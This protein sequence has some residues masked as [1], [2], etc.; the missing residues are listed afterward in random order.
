MTAS[1][2][3]PRLPRTG[4]P[5]NGPREEMKGDRELCMAAVTQDGKALQWASE[6]MKGDRE[7]CTAAVA[8]NRRALEFASEEMKGDRELCTAAVAQDG[9]ALQYCSE[10]MKG[11]RELCTAAVAQNW[12]ALEWAGE[13]MKGDRELC[14][15]AVTQNG[16]GPA[17]HIAFTKLPPPCL[18]SRAGRKHLPVVTLKSQARRNVTKVTTFGPRK[19]V[20]SAGPVGGGFGCELE[21]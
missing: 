10:E 2:A 21:L 18:V 9:R 17:N 6:E 14:M 20:R 8:Q 5:S 13:E 15:A 4:R 11:A 7:L 16:L 1:C 3:R 12:E 19:S